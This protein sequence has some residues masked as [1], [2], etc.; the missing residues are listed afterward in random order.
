MADDFVLML[1]VDLENY[2]KFPTGRRRRHLS[3][4][5]PRHPPA[6][7]RRLRRRA[8]RLQRPVPGRPA[9]HRLLAPRRWPRRFLPWSEEYMLLCVD[10]WAPRWPP[11]RRR[12]DGRDRVGRMERPDRPRA[13]AHE[14]ASSSRPAR[15]TRTRTSTCAE[16]D[17][18]GTRVVYTGLFTPAPDT[19]RPHQGAARHL[20]P[21]EPRVPA[22]VHRG[23][24]RPDRRPLQP[25]RDV[26]HPVHAVGRRR[27]AGGQEAQGR[28]PR[29]HRAT[30]SRTG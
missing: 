1:G 13:R 5:R 16:P 4:G 30:R 18:A 15:T 23:M 6:A 10:G 17:R 24:G 11:V 7:R 19:G 21:R 14:G 3:Q 12:G 20:V 9:L 25:R 2:P 27:P 22:A 26:R 28:V 29:H 8:P